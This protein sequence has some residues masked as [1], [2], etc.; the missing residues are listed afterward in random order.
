MSVTQLT[1]WRIPQV[2]YR[3]P[4]TNSDDCN[5]LKEC[6]TVTGSCRPRAMTGESCEENVDPTCDESN[7][8]NNSSAFVELRAQDIEL[9]FAAMTDIAILCVDA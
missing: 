4:C 8:C 1:R 3:V 7:F 5:A 2:T 9:A 6:D